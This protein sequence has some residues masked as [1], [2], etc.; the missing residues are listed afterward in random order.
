MHIQSFCA[1]TLQTNCYTLLDAQSGRF[2][3]IDAPPE[4][5]SEVVAFAR[6]RNACLEAIWLTHSHWDHIAEIATLIQLLGRQREPGERFSI[7]VHELDAGNLKSPGSDGIA[8]PIAIS[9]CEPTRLLRD[10]QMLEFAGVSFRILH[11]P[12]HSPGSIC[13][14]CEEKAMLF[15]GDTLFRGKMGSLSLP[16]AQPSAMMHSLRTLMQLPPATSIFPGHG[17]SSTL[18]EE[19]A[20]MQK[21]LKSI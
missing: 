16:T 7:A 12:G 18:Q 20:W 15:T 11:T 8:P 9:S 1:G 13:L 6:D 19:R 4:S 10:G 17:P 3:L 14:Y 2:V 21:R 5:T